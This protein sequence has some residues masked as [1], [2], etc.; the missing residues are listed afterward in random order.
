M[1]AGRGS[2][3]QLSFIATLEGDQVPSEFQLFPYGLV[4]LRGESPFR[5]D[6][7]AMD[8]VIREFAARGID[9]VVDY[10]H[11]TEGGRY[12]S[13]DGKAPAAGWIKRLINKGKQGLWAAVDWTAR[14]KAH[15][16]AKEYRYFSPVFMI[17]K[18]SGEL[19]ELLRVA[20]TNSPRLDG[21]RPIVASFSHP[22]D[23]LSVGDRRKINRSFGLPE[24]QPIVAREEG[25]IFGIA[26]NPGDGLS[27]ED[28]RKINRSFGLPENQPILAKE[29]DTQAIQAMTKEDCREIDRIFALWRAT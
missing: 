23:G 7:A 9:I 8:K 10:E 2:L 27:D 17:S 28:R 25:E 5:V 20:L 18:S 4:R 26:N 6:E 1:S 22:S 29:E 15:L 16:A 24:D 13:P 14:A 12:S 11:Q 19:A 21:I 3:R